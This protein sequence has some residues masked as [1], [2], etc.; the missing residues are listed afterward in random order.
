MTRIQG[1]TDERKQRR[2]KSDCLGGVGTL[3]G[4]VTHSFTYLLPFSV[5]FTLKGKN[6]LLLEQ[7]LSFESEPQFGRKLRKQTGS[8]ESCSP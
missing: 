8:H 5:G 4:E 2:C 6:L 1:Q 7:I 3:S